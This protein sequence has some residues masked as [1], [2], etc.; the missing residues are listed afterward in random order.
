MAL[1][2][3]TIGGQSCDI[4]RAADGPQGLKERV[5]VWEKPGVAGASAQRLGTAAGRFSYR[6][7]K[8]ESL[9]NCITWAEAI[10]ALVGTVVTIEDGLETWTSRCL[11]LTASV[12]SRAKVVTTAPAKDH[13]FEMLVEGKIQEE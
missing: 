8:F 7:I 6:A 4:I 2:T 11:V 5:S 1:P 13:R 12:V 9:A 3:Y 10:E